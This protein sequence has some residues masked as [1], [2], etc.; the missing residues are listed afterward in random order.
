MGKKH[1]KPKNDSPPMTLREAAARLG[2]A[3]VTMRRMIKDGKIQAYRIG[4]PVTGHFRV[5][6][7]ALKD[8]LKSVEQ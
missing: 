4:D 7:Q 6:E 2:C 8:Y 3:A 5:T 1:K